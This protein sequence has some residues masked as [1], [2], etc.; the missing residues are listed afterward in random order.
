MSRPFTIGL[1]SLACLTALSTAL[2]T[3][4]PAFAEGNA[5]SGLEVFGGGITKTNPQGF[6]PGQYSQA[7]A[8]AVMIKKDALQQVSWFKSRRQ[9]SIEDDSPIVSHSGGAGGGGGA[10]LSPASFGSNLGG[11]RMPTNLK[12]ATFGHMVTPELPQA[13]AARPLMRAS[14]GAFP[15][16]Q[17]TANAG[18]FSA[19]RAAASY[20]NSYASAPAVSAASDFEAARVRDVKARLL[21]R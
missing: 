13:P 5:E 8:G 14:Q 3:G 17:A 10:P 6:N 15:G 1:F 9:V 19:P 7:G 21:G 12:Q 20:G 2:S 16:K 18:N 11:M 4:A